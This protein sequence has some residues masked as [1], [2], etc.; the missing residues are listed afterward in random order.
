MTDPP[1]TE[2]HST[3]RT[4]LRAL[5]AAGAL[6]AVGSRTARADP[7]DGYSV[8]QNGDCTPIVPLSGDRS[9]EELYELRIPEEYGGDNGATDPGE[10]PYYGSLGIQDLQRTNTTVAFLYDGPEG[11]SLVVVHGALNGDDGDGGR[12]I[13]WTLEGEVL[14]DGEWVVKDD[15]YTDPDTGRQADSNLDQWDVTGETHTIDWTYG[16]G[17]TDGG[18]FRPLGDEFELVIDPRYNEAAAL[19]DGNFYDGRVTNLVFLSFPNGRGE[20][21]AV[22]LDLDERLRLR[23]GSCDRDD[24]EDGGGGDDGDDED[25]EDEDDEDD[26]KED[27]DDEEDGTGEV[28]V[29]FLVAGLINTRSNGLVTVFLFGND[30]LDTGDVDVGSLRFGPPGVV[31]DGGGASPEHDG[32][33]GGGAPLILHFR[34]G[35]TGFEGGDDTAKLAGETTDG[36]VLAGTKAVK[37][38]PSGDEDGED[39]DDD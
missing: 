14:S 10:G 1:Q 17:R 8:V 38:L 35:D 24:E 11:V 25:D 6:T 37:V 2:R 32:H 13:S 18:A 27:E 26:E 7:A 22:S 33:G 12:G 36:T 5:G 15:F 16:G 39:D 9:V 3:R 28:E 23:A 34:V 30:D 20:P 19:W 29:D 31:D 21:E 4:L